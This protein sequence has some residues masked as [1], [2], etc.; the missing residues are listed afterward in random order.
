MVA[1]APLSERIDALL[2]STNPLADDATFLRRVYLDLAGTLPDAKTA[3]AFLA[4][5][6]ADKRTRL[7]DQLLAA[8]TY[9]TRMADLFHIH[10]MERLGDDADWMAYLRN[11]FAENR[12]W[13]VM[14]GDM[15][16]PRPNEKAKGAN[17]W[18]R[19]R[20]E[21]YGQQ[22]V[23]RPGL[24]RDIGRLFLGRDLRC[25]QCHD[26]LFIDSYKQ[27]HFQGLFAFV[28]N[29]SLDN[30]KALVE[31]PL[32][33]RVA[34][35]SVFG[36]G[37]GET[38]PRLPDGRE[39]VLPEKG[40]E[41]LTP[42]D[43]KK[44]T[45]G[46]PR[47]SPLSELARELPSH[48]D[49]A[50]NFV[51]RIWWAL[52]GRGIVHPL[53]LHHGGNPPSSPR[54]LN[55]LAEE[56][57]ASKYDIKALVRAIVQSNAYQRSSELPAGEKLD[58]ASFRVALERRLSP[59][60]RLQAT[61]VATGTSL[62]EKGL[63]TARLKFTK[64]F[65]GPPREPEEEPAPSLKGALFL[66]NDPLLLSWLEPRPGNLVHQLVPLKN[67]ALAEQLYLQV[68]TRRPD[69]DERRSVTQ[70]LAQAKNRERSIGRLVWALLT[71]TEFQVNH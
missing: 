1:S 54:L 27:G 47:L 59:E 2:P 29:A 4:N 71:S 45:P 68:L 34:Y 21:N 43:P 42:P 32:L 49:F 5:P 33:N 11:S 7:I 25:A 28:Q 19:K 3:Q 6:A 41:W 48:P 64:A 17:F 53:D 63:A 67:E 35:V 16:H 9:A 60:Q 37:K 51:N 23:D 20:L 24:A 44:R 8:P 18:I 57:V 50:R 31:R 12:P 62:D 26:H 10:W 30:T 56:L 52:M 39:I 15:V 38:A 55:L 61:L 69:D 36:K 58:P 70:V 22:E 46:V 13:D 40:Q 66:L 65:A 14:A